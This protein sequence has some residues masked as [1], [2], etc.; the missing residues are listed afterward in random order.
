MAKFNFD[1]Q[2]MQ[3]FINDMAK[4]KNNTKKIAQLMTR[5]GAEVVLQNAKGRVPHPALA[6]HIKLSRTYDTPSDGG[7]N[8]KVYISGYIPF[9]GNRR[10]FS[11]RA[12]E[13]G[14]TYY[15]SKGIPA[16]FV[17]QIYEYGTSKR[18]TD[19][20]LYRGRVNKRPFFRSSFKKGEIEKAMEEEFKKQTGGIFDE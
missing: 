18:Y 1:D 12:K 11:R 2:V 14:K 8:T 10:W 9:S 17:A 20:D 5:A 19:E 15:T 4:I 13:G 16:D 6:S 3:D 7:I